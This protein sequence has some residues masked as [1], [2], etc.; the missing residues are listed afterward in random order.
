MV[1]ISQ[2]IHISNHHDGSFPAAVEPR[3]GGG[4]GAFKI[5]LHP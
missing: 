1:G 4:S 2:C 3:G 5:R